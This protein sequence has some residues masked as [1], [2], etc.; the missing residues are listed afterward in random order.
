[1]SAKIKQLREQRSKFIA[2]ARAICTKAETEKRAMSAVETE[3]FDALMSDADKAKTE[4]DGLEVEVRR[5][6]RLIK[7]EQELQESA[8]RQAEPGSPGRGD[9]DRGEGRG[10]GADA[11]IEFRYKT[12]TGVERRFELRGPTTTEKHQKEFRAWLCGGREPE[13]RTMQAD[14][15]TGGGYLIA[16]M[17]MAAGLIQRVDDAVFVRQHATVLPPLASAQSLGAPSLDGDLDDAEWVAEL[18]EP[19]DDEADFG[20]R[21]LNPHAFAKSMRISRRLLR[22]ASMNPEQILLDRLEYKCA[23]T[24]EKAFLTGSGVKKPLGIF[25]ASDDGVPTSRDVSTGN[26]TTAMTFDG[27]IEA[28]YSLKSQYWARA[29]WCFHRDGVKQLVKIKD[30]NGGYVWREGS[31]K[32]GEPDRLLDLPQDVSEFVP[33]TFTTGLYVGALCDWS[34]YWIVDSL[35]LEIQRLVETRARQNQVEF[36]AR[37]ETDGMPVLA[38]AFARVKLG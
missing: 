28:K 29:R 21:E 4:I 1:M 32:M 22:L 37:K 11:P 2:D 7:H 23:V 33:N 20:R 24:E 6:D 15:D 14:S 8:G 26:T 34:R 19:T 27:L 13:L 25:T 38:E 16:P 30:G 17:Q 9:P 3:Q 12:R 18:G 10:R 31:V 35:Q 36:I 5:L